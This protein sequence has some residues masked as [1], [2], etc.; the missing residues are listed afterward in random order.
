MIY[1]LIE[2]KYHRAV[3]AIK[4]IAEI[5]NLALNDTTIIVRFWS[6]NVIV[7]VEG[8]LNYSKMYFQ[9]FLVLVGISGF[10]K[11]LKSI[12]FIELLKVHGKNACSKV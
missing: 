5:C 10:A 7:L 8:D 4:L 9:R 12:Q 2:A 6:S 3:N 11:L 1:W